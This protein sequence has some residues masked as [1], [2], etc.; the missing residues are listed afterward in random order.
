MPEGEARRKLQWL[1]QGDWLSTRLHALVELVQNAAIRH[2]QNFTV[3]GDC[4]WPKIGEMTKSVLL[5]HFL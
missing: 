1:Q 2:V 3:S 4:R 5:G